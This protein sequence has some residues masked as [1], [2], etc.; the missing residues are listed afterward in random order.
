MWIQL[1]SGD[2]LT[3]TLNSDHIVTFRAFGDRTRLVH[4][5]GEILVLES[6]AA[7][8]KALRL[9]NIAA[10]QREINDPVSTRYSAH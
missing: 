4:L 1:T 6:D 7:I 9:R 5:G 8:I 3:I 10:T 2:G